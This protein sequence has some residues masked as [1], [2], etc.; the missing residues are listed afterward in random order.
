MCG[1]FGRINFADKSPV[2]ADIIK[3]ALSQ[4]VHRGPDDDGIL[5]DGHAGL[6]MR[7]LSIIDIKTGHQPITNET[8]DI[9]I[10]HS[11]EIYNYRELRE[12]LIRKGH[13]FKTSS[14][15]ESILHLY[16]EYGEKCLAMLNGMFAFAIWDK[17]NDKMFVARDRAGIKPLF[18]SLSAGSLMFSSEIR[19]LLSAGVSNE[20]DREALVNYFSFYYISSP[21][22]IYKN[23]R[24]LPPGHFIEV[25]RSN[26]EIKQYWDLK[27]FPE[28]KTEQ[29]AVESIKETLARAVKSHLQ[30]EVPLGVFLSSGMDSTSILAMMH[31]LVPKIKTYTIGYENG[32]SFNE[33]KEARLVAEKYGAEHNECVLKPGQVPGFITDIT[34]HL[35]EPHGDWTQA[36]FYYL[37]R[38]SKKDITVALS[39]AG[40]D[41]LFA[42]YPTLTAAKLAGYYRKLPGI[43]K[44]IIKKTVNKLPSSYD[45]L[46]FDFKAKSFVAGAEME[47]EK[48]HMRYKEIF[49]SEERKNLLYNVSEIDPFSVYGQYTGATSDMRLLDRLLYF[50]FKVFLPDCALHV[51]DMATMMNAQECRVPFLDNEMLEL[52]ARIPVSM[53]MRGV[54]T[55]Y[56]L[57]K[58]L[59]EFLPKEIT[60]M[61]KK[62][63][64]MPTSFW[65]KKELKDFVGSLIQ[66]S[67]KRNAGLLDFNYVR[68]IFSEHTSGRKDNTRKLTCLASFMI[69][70][71]MYQ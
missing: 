27:F 32:K 28:I 7:R 67:E 51:T 52:S 45:R 36:G 25:G 35:A 22:T 39:G 68:R 4:M 11:G 12:T 49:S 65:L 61:P 3:K 53:K 13:S 2:S 44:E 33:L 41:E 26:V 66:N 64:A 20:V 23:I 34:K 14:D 6:G 43:M 47:P 18:Y 30:S 42:G 1:I 62:G 19:A 40:G 5:I 56:I 24:R 59:K 69:W 70:Q 29:E 60:R 48:A 10:I 17:K 57:R 46:S 37:S 50:D 63:F 8:G 54:T 58:A 71:E 31:G 15:T 55:K 21:Q 16:E 9:S 38:E